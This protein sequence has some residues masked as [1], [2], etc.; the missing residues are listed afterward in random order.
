M[1]MCLSDDCISEKLRVTKH[2]WL[3]DWVIL[4][5]NNMVNHRYCVLRIYK[6]TNYIS[7]IY[8]YIYIYYRNKIH[9]SYKSDEKNI[10]NIDS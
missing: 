1:F 2:R 4:T 8:I 9:Y 7:Y 10:K 3:C 6:H 5:L